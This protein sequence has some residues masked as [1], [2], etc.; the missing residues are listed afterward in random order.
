MD[1]DKN[2]KVKRWKIAIQGYDAEIEHIPG[3]SNIIADPLSRLG[4]K[5]DS[6]LGLANAIAALR[7]V[8]EELQL[9][10]REDIN[11]SPKPTLT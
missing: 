3:T 8:P 11:F 7:E 10:L 5:E 6:K 4:M 1:A 9:L 2:Q